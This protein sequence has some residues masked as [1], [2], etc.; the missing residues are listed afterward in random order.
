VDPEGLAQ[1]AQAVDEGEEVSE[2]ID[3]L[4]LANKVLDTPQRPGVT[5]PTPLAQ[6]RRVK[7][8]A[9]QDRTNLTG[10]G[11]LVGLPPVRL[12]DLSRAKV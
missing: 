6:G 2:L 4:L 10:A 3:A 12:G 8:V 11:R 1:R 9:A 5:L 7:P